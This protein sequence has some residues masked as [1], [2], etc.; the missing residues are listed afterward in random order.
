M[1]RG[2]ALGT[3][4]LLLVAACGGGPGVAPRSAALAEPRPDWSTGLDRLMPA[5]QACLADRTAG[6]AAVGVTKA[7]PIGR[8]LAGVRVLRED[9]GRVDCVAAAEGDRVFLT[10]RVRED[11]RLQGERDP[12]YTP[13]GLPPPKSPCLANAAADGGWLSYDV[14]RDPRPI[15]SAAAPRPPDRP[16]PSVQEG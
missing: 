10:E 3:F 5:I 15:G 1:R 12:L 13:Q 16:P 9:G 14:C 7:W 4:G 2:A 11:S 6:E 8:Q